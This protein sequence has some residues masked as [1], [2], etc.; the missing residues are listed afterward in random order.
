MSLVR[1]SERVPPTGGL[2]ADGFAN[3]LGRPALDPV[4]LVLREAAQNIW[5]ARVRTTGAP[6]PR[7]LVRMRTLTPDQSVAF[8]RELSAGDAR[9]AEP[10]DGNALAWHLASDAPI[11]VLEICDFGTMGLGGGADPTS[12]Q[13][14]FVRFFFDIGTP[15]EGGGDGGTY[16]YGRSS[17]YLASNART[18]LVDTQVFG[19]AG[20]RRMM[21]CRLGPAYGKQRL[22]EKK[23][24]Y[25]GRHFWGG[26]VSGDVVR[27]L[28]GD[29]ARSLSATLGMPARQP[30]E[31]GTSVLIPWPMVSEVDTGRHLVGILLHNLWPK[32]VQSKGRRPME[33]AVEVDGIAIPIPDPRTHPQYGPFAAALR[34][35]R[36]RTTE[37]GVVP[38]V[39]GRGRDTTGHLA[40]EVTHAAPV[41]APPQSEDGSPEHDFAR[42]VHHVALMR[43]SELVVRYQA[44]PGVASDSQWGAVFMCSDKPEIRDAFAASEPPAHDDWV[45]DRLPDSQEAIVRL[46]LRRVREQVERH[47]GVSQNPVHG[48]VGGA[49]TSLAAAADRFAHEFLS[50]DGT[51]AVEKGSIGGGGGGG[52]SPLQPFRF[53]SIRIE[54]GQTIARFVARCPMAVV[55]KVSARAIVMMGGRSDES[56][57][58]DVVPPEIL[59]WILPDGRGVS[60]STC[61]VR[62]AGDYRVD[63]SFKGR[64]AI[65]IRHDILEADALEVSE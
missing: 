48:G 2:N 27:P 56:L 35:V 41:P 7:M 26:H 3:I 10:H 17:L 61:E 38:I 30:S 21:A 65:D 39:V 49:G 28:E 22:G 55:L 46:S 18:I 6:P 5:D 11:R 50:G 40:I 59:G 20:S 8:R 32:L 63:V 33:I 45:P 31:S 12:E 13:G 51:G 16:G 44:F 58:D 57:P 53:D 4:A 42:G 25:T 15:H 14:H 52:G 47:F 29:V 37:A 43:P 9:S 23:I 60:G 36:A 64:Y 19:D 24:R 54:D 1:L 62:Q 34:L